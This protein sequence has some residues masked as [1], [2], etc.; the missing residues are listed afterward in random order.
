[1]AK[2]KP[3][4]RK[5]PP[6]AVPKPAASRVKA[7]AKAAP[8]PAKTVARRAPAKPA[9]ERDT[10]PRYD[11]L[12]VRVGAPKGAAWGVFGDDDQVG[13][14]NLLTAARVKA[15]AQLIRTGKVFPLDLPVNI[16]DPPLFM[17]GKHEHK[18]IQYPGAEAFVLD[19]YL[20]NYY[21]QSSSQW[22][23]LAHVIHPVDGPYNGIPREQITGRGGTKLGIEN[24]AQR[25]I[26][27]RGVLIDIG[28]HYK[29]V[30][31]SIDY[32]QP[33]TIPFE[34]I[35]ATLK[36][37]RTKLQPGDILLIRIGWTE[38][39]LGADMQTKEALARETK[40]PGI[41]ASERMARWLW[42]N[43]VAAV[44]SDSPALE[45]LPKANPDDRFLHLDMLAYFGMPIGEM[46]DLEGLAE[47]CAADK[48]YECFLTSA[49]LNIPGGV[50]SPPNALAIK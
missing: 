43:R 50:G 17:R 16:P 34:D 7:R 48:R 25:G 46:W 49:P 21:P 1:M 4:T 44:A 26:A 33:E 32:T 47:D 3:K 8:K 31:K 36:D 20:N 38:F 9:R 18:V 6:K 10:L 45:P 13:T 2:A 12:P 19:D 42:D 11:Q 14:I 5:T 30:G 41:E 23:A 15:A 35:E 39:Y 22:D 37:Q 24:L 27:G 40:V 28:R 29:K